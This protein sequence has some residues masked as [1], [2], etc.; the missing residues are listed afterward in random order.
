MHDD[1]PLVDAFVRD[2]RDET[3]RVLYRRHAPAMYRL[4]VRLLGRRDADAEDA[5]QEAWIR[6]VGRLAQFRWESSLR[7]WLCGIAVNCTRERMRRDPGNL[8]A[9]TEPASGGPVP[10]WQTIDLERAIAQLPCG[11]RAVLVLHDVHGY[12]HDEIARLLDIEPSS[13]RSQLTRARQTLR[14]RLGPAG[15]ARPMSRHT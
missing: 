4:I 9:D 10:Q 6:A 1:R 14:A 2:R 15:A 5:L 3:F 7:T 11:A 12:T 8:V 13:S